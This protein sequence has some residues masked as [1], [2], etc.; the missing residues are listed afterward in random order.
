MEITRRTD[1]AIRMMTA[2]ADAG[3]ACPISVRAL[4]EAQ[5]V[6]Y[7]FSRTVQR[8]LMTA[9]LVAATRGATG[10]LCLTRPSTEITLLQIV[11]ATQGTPSIA[12]CSA[13]PKWCGRSGTCSAHRVWCEIDALVRE[14]LGSKT[15]AGLSS[16]HGR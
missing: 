6:P 4:A 16:K 15:L 14:Q 8:D 7:A 5:G 9:G 10:G 13:D 3:E 1:Y 2:L 11:E 12:T